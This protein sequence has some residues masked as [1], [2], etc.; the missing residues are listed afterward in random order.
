MCKRKKLN[1][2]DY[3][4]HMRWKTRKQPSACNLGL[5]A[6]PWELGGKSLEQ[7]PGSLSVHMAG[8]L[9]AVA[10]MAG[11]PLVAGW[12]SSS[13][14]CTPCRQLLRPW[15]VSLLVTWPSCHFR[16]PLLPEFPCATCTVPY[17][18]L[19]ID[20]PSSSPPR[21]LFHSTLLSDLQPQGFSL[22]SINPTQKQNTD[23]R[24]SSV[25]PF[26][27]LELLNHPVSTHPLPQ[28]S[29]FFCR[30]LTFGDYPP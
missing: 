17:T 5:E 19:V 15:V 16:V 4:V 8:K 12:C 26:S 27:R 10:V 29:P 18:I 28:S 30:V 24:E 22:E 7:A 25:R 9:A 21:L 6:T 11:A 23:F 14:S 1:S 13:P 20:L 3:S 2:T